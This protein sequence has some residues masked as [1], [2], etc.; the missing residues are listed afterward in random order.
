MVSQ[1]K[2]MYKDEDPDLVF[3]ADSDYDKGRQAGTQFLKS[4][5]LGAAPKVL[6]NGVPLD[7]SGVGIIS[8]RVFAIIYFYIEPKLKESYRLPPRRYCI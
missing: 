8:V 6:L 7:D 1:F 5:G 4:S 2:R 3:G